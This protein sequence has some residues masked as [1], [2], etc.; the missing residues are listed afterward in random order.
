MNLL[1]RVLLLVV[2]VVIGAGQH[3]GKFRL[4]RHS[5]WVWYLPWIEEPLELQQLTSKK[6]LVMANRKEDLAGQPP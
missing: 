6:P 4:V 5:A 2:V 3:K 1:G